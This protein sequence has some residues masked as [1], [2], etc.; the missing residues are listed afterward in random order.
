MSNDSPRKSDANT[1]A[2][3]DLSRVARPKGVGN[4]DFGSMHKIVVNISPSLIS[5]AYSTELYNAMLQTLILTNG[6]PL[7]TL[8]FTE[9]DL[10]VYLTLLLRERIKDVRK[11]RTLFPRGDQ[12]VK[13]PH[14]FYLA[15]YELGDVV[16]EQ[17]HVWLEAQFDAAELNGLYERRADIFTQVEDRIVTDEV[18]MAAWKS[19]F[20]QYTGEAGEREFIYSMSRSLK[21]LERYGF[22][23]GSALPRGLTGD[24]SFMLFIWAEGKLQHPDP[25]V[26]PGTALLASLLAFSRSTTLLNPYISYGPENAY[27]ILLK[28]VT[29]P[30]GKDKTS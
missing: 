19:E 3:N 11:Q 1:Q 28:E 9:S 20:M 8:P 30:R 27:R 5:R 12:D 2:I 26:E 17:R 4:V 13:I 18:K 10:Y 29:L 21:M 7:A 16:D 6:N 25:N 23:N 24:M 14:F 22:V 15:L